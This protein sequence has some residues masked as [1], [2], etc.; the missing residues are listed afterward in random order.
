MHRAVRKSVGKESSPSVGV[1]DNQII[2]TDSYGGEAI[3]IDDSKKVK[4][5][6]RHIITDTL[7]LLLSSVVCTAN[8]KD[9]KK[10]FDVIKTDQP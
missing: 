8:E 10:T 9:G 2:N 1:I 5:R 4:G 3:D 6:K 7:G